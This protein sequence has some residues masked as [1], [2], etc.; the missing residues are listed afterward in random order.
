MYIQSF[1]NGTGFMSKLIFPEMYFAYWVDFLITFKHNIFFIIYFGTGRG[2]RNKEQFVRTIFLKIGI[3]IY[4]M[5][6]IVYLHYSLLK[7]IHF[8]IPMLC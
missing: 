4:L 5:R 2:M 7:A 1:T 8:N 6:F 3:F